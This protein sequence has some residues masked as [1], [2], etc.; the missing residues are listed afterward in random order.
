MC[1][2]SSSQALFRS[3]RLTSMKSLFCTFLTLLTSLNAL[4]VKPRVF[5]PKNP[6]DAHLANAESSNLRKILY[7]TYLSRDPFGK[8]LI[9]TGL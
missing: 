6:A 5:D 9:V 1:A 3:I 4:E 8:K 2:H 7:P